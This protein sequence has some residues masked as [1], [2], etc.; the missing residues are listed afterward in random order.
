M[1]SGHDRPESAVT[2]TGIRSKTPEV[3]NSIKSTNTYSVLKPRSAV[4]SVNV[5]GEEF[6][7]LLAKNVAIIK[8]Q[9]VNFDERE[10]AAPYATCRYL[11]LLVRPSGVIGGSF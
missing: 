7:R 5:L 8:Y 6:T 3:V 10:G 9:Q 4:R 11:G 2:L 1:R